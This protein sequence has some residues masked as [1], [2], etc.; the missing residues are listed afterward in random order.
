MLV[1]IATAENQEIFLMFIL[2]IGVAK[3]TSLRYS[4]E[5]RAIVR[6]N[7]M[8][9]ATL[10]SKGQTT[11]P[12]EIRN[13]LGL[14]MG[15]KIEFVIEEGRVM[16]APLTINVSELKGM[17]PKPKKKVSIEDMNHAIAKRGADL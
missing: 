13:Y 16:L 10:T 2:S 1:I 7:F 15:D 5:Y 8:A 12:Y 3:I 9:I 11:I 6:I 4:K 14:K 17:L